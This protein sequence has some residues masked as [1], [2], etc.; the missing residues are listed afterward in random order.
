MRHHQI[1]VCVAVVLI[2]L[3]FGDEED[4]DA[5]RKERVPSTDKRLVVIMVEGLANWFLDDTDVHGHGDLSGFRM[6][7]ENGELKRDGSILV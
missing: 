6:I 2:G 4:H 5:L 3:V 1:I 7:E